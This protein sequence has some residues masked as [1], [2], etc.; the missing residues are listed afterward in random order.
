MK[1]INITIPEE[2]HKQLKI[3]AATQGTTIKE[4]SINLLEQRIKRGG[5]A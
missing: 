5:R 2:L 4:L 1:N 3:A